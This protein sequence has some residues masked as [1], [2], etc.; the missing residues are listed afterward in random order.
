MAIESRDLTVPKHR[1]RANPYPYH[2]GNRSTSTHPRTIEY[3]EEV[4]D[5]GRGEAIQGLTRDVLIHRSLEVSPNG[6]ITIV[7]I[8]QGV[9]LALLAQNTFEKPSVLVVA[10]SV[11]LMMIFVV[12]F[13]FYLTMSVMLRWAPS[14]LDS[15]LPF[16]IAGLEI[17]PAFF[18]GNAAGWSMWLAALWF[19]IVAGL[20][21]TAKWS[22]PSHFGRRRLAHTRW[23]QLQHEL[24]LSASCGGFAVAFCG[25][26]AAAVP[27]G[28]LA[29]GLLSTLTVLVTVGVVVWRIEIRSAQIHSIYRVHR[30]PFN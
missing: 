4:K 8:I 9:A 7:S 30:P 2:E 23:H 6:F 22:P 12:V 5:A 26:L 3:E 17:P 25:L 28:R 20:W 27:A 18:L 10:Q 1:H 16:A 19:V 21:T 14:F 24:Q 11:A 13:Y 15:F 29:F